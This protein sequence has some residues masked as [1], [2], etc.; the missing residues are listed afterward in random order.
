MNFEVLKTLNINFDS[1]TE[2]KFSKYIEVF[3]T[4][5]SHTNLISKNVI[6]F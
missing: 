5:N 6:F 2:E 3:K 1:K 4:Y